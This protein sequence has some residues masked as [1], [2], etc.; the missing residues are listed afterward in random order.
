MQIE[1]EI[2]CAVV[3]SAV[4]IN[5]AMITKVE[6]IDAVTTKVTWLPG[7]IADHLMTSETAEELVKRINE[8]L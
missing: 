5:P 6:M 4:Y 3:R 8:A 2:G 7:G 1:G